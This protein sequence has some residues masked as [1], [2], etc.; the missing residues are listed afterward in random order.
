[1]RIR[2]LLFGL[3]GGLSLIPVIF[4]GVW[5]QSRTL[6]NL[7]NNVD[8]HHLLI[9]KNVGHALERYDRDVQAT[10][11]FLSQTALLERDL[12]PTDAFL[13]NLG[14]R[15]ICVAEISTRKVVRFIG[16]PEHPCPD[17]VP[18]ARFEFFLEHTAEHATYTPVAANPQGEPTLY[19]LRKVGPL[20]AIGAL[21]TTYIVDLGKSIS[22]GE[23]GHAAIV[24][25]TGRVLAHPLDSWQREMKN[26]AKLPVVEKMLSGE[27][28]V[29]TFY[30]PAL[31]DDM[32]AGYTSVNGTGWGV[33]IPQPVSELELRA[34]EERLYALGVIALGVFA[35]IVVSWFLMGMIARPVVEV[36]E[37][38]RQ[39]ASGEHSV[40]L[41]KP[42]RFGPAE[43]TEMTNA[44][45]SM[46]QAVSLS[47][48]DQTRALQEA[49]EA[50][51]AKT[52]FLAHMSHE[53]R[54]PLNSIIGF[55]QM[56]DE[57][58]FGPIGNARYADYVSTIKESGDHMLDLVN[59][60]LDFTKVEAGAY[61]FEEEIVDLNRVV[62]SC[63]TI[64]E[65]KRAEFQISIHP[66]IF[67]EEIILRADERA[68]R[69]II[70]NLLSNAIK[71]NWHG[72]KIRV[73][74]YRDDDHLDIA[75]IDNG[76]GIAS[77]ELPTAMEPFGKV[78]NPSATTDEGTG[79]GLPLCKKLTELHGGSLEIQSEFGKGTTVIVRLPADRIV[80]NDRAVAV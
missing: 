34:R 30:S 78:S 15:H 25:H 73:E 8:E 42:G 14:F 9:A 13:E 76:I 80:N 35:A 43:L 39:V 74:A 18:K 11:E 32:I 22:F 5:P 72:G 29:M 68:L 28:G 71:Y 2:Y 26:I 56:I 16:G 36:A 21:K 19:L 61:E 53:F 6:E 24:D 57:E 64:V 62:S 20:L 77:H 10:F 41:P 51:S 4:F 27:P 12:H 46:M 59:G 60:I 3:I 50:N 70:I 44:F 1:M 67:A 63:L 37:A 75:V 38:A 45:N 17:I 31:K 33:M 52:I 69:Q 48:R 58:V 65:G 66:N 7:L 54:T 49:T 47:R 40:V 79:L 55:S 23:K